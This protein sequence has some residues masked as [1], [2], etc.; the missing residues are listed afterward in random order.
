MRTHLSM[1]SWVR[2]GLFIKGHF[3]DNDESY[4]LFDTFSKL[5]NN[6]EK[7][8]KNCE[9]WDGFK[10]HQ[11]YDNF[12]IFVNRAKTYDKKLNRELNDEI[13]TLAKNDSNNKKI[14]IQQAS[15]KLKGQYDNYIEFDIRKGVSASMFLIKRYRNK[16]IWE[17]SKDDTTGELYTHRRQR[18]S[19]GHKNH[20]IS[21]AYLRSH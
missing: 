4:Q 8:G 20:R 19:D 17:K 2:M 14:S 16:F 3:G 1:T 11:N 6:Y 5:G 10:T 18:S 12:G 21:R 13:K 7:N 9:I 15:V